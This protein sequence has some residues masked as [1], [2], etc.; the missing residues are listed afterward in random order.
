MANQNEKRKVRDQE[1]AASSRPKM[2]K[3]ARLL[4]KQ[5]KQRLQAKKEREE[6]QSKQRL[7]AKKE[8]EE[9]LDIAEEKLGIAEEAL[10][11]SKMVSVAGFESSRRLQAMEVAGRLEWPE[12]SD[13]AFGIKIEIEIDM[14][15]PQPLLPYTLSEEEEKREAEDNAR[16][17]DLIWF[18]EDNLIHLMNH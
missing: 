3:K 17:V 5:S 16:L 4:E 11:F 15:P 10:E 2:D 8:R 13:D 9:K 1:P 14:N 12:A 7:Q 18:E 6:K